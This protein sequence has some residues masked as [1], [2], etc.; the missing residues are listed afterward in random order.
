MGNQSVSYLQ[1]DFKLG[2]Y[3]IKSLLGRGGMAEVYRAYNPDLAQDVAIKVLNP[4]FVKSDEASTRFRREAQAIAGL[5]HS[6]IVRV[7]DFAVQDHY[8]YMVM[9]L[10]DGVPLDE[11]LKEYPQGMP[12]D[13]ITNFFGQLASAVS[14]AHEQGVI[15]RDIKPS[16][17]IIVE[18]RLVLTDFGLAKIMGQASLTMTGTSSGTPAYMAPEQ[19]AGEE[20]T[21]RTDIYTLGVVLYEMATGRVPFQG[22]TFANVLIQHL[23]EAPKRPTEVSSTI[24]PV[25]EPVILRAMAKQP[26]LRYDDVNQMLKEISGTSA[27]ISQETMKISTQVIEAMSSPYFDKG[28]ATYVGLP[29]SDPNISVA[30]IAQHKTEK[31]RWQ[32][33]A[34]VGL[35]SLILLAG[36]LV[37]TQLG[38]DDAPDNTGNN[39]EVAD[40]PPA[41]DRMVYVPEGSFQMGSA[42]G[43]DNE[44]PVHEVQ[45]HEFFIDKYEVTNEDYYAFVQETGFYPE[46]D[47]WERLDSSIWHIEG[48]EV[49]LIG[50]L[51]DRWSYN[52]TNILETEN[53]SMTVDLN[54][55]DETGTVIVEFDGIIRPEDGIEYA[56]RIRIEHDVFETQA[57]FNEGGVGD[58]VL[59]HGDSGQESSSLPRVISPVATWGQARLFVNDEQIYSDLGAHFMLLGGIR[60]DDLR[61]LKADGTCCYS[62]L[63]PSNGLVDETTQQMTLFLFK[64]SAAGSYGDST[65]GEI[66]APVENVWLN[67]HVQQV[68][69]VERPAE[70]LSHFPEGTENMPVTGITWNAAQ[71]YCEWNDKRLP[72]EAEWEYAA[73][74][75]QNFLY[76]WGDGQT[77]NDSIPANVLEGMGLHDV[78]SFEDGVSPFGAYDMAGNAWE[79]VSDWYAADYYA[80]SESDNPLGPNSGE[81]RVVRGG[82]YI[83]PDPSGIIEFRTTHRRPLD[84]SQ[85]LDDVGFRCASDYFEMGA[86]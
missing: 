38:D 72:T 29:A 39:S 37:I 20:I 76:P 54:A 25:L 16:N 11:L 46:P 17:M 62:L 64:G 61:I 45:V 73:R 7:Y 43:R 1:P 74:G 65:P 70:E 67:I 83:Q 23:K 40:V 52:G 41:P 22:D 47:V 42:Q 44:S 80:N 53:A 12:H 31:R 59:M 6:N 19:A 57:N 78:G 26:D 2:K 77:I 55:D 14:Y 49:Y 33:L 15:H 81:Q 69:I 10:L 34:G 75:V 79:W 27:E 30:E 51:N 68:D 86:Q 18:D 24:N 85:Q 9:E 21:N 28:G 60:D 48:S 13:Q 71:A 50:D 84:P 56:G 5:S 58:H 82:S 3:T 35:I 8:H 66:G 63:S 4:S 32:V 36:A